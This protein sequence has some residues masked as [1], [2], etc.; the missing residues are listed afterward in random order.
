MLKN[1]TSSLLIAMLTSRQRRALQTQF[2]KS[3]NLPPWALEYEDGEELGSEF[4]EWA[5]KVKEE[6]YEEN[7]D[8]HI[9]VSSD[10]EGGDEEDNSHSGHT[11]TNPEDEGK[12]APKTGTFTNITVDVDDGHWSAGEAIDDD[13]EADSYDDEDEDDVFDELNG[14]NKAGP[15]G[16]ATSNAIVASGDPTDGESLCDASDKE[17]HRPDENTNSSAFN[18]DSDVGGYLS[19]AE[20]MQVSIPPPAC[21]TYIKPGNE[22]AYIDGIDY[23]ARQKQTTRSPLSMLV[24]QVNT[25]N[26][27]NA[28]EVVTS[29][30]AHIPTND[31]ET[32]NNAPVDAASDSGYSAGTDDVGNASDSASTD[33]EDRLA[34]IASSMHRS[35]QTRMKMLQLMSQH[36]LGRAGADQKR[37]RD[38][39]DEDEGFD[40]LP[41]GSRQRKI[42][43][44]ECGEES[45]E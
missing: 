11:S 16:P 33:T 1:L 8:G 3:G 44:R 2:N 17:N 28:E 30:E 35:F 42:T 14:D 13:D 6:T 25:P 36:C 24:G 29:E 5:K 23:Q 40:H 19:D 4:V 41:P 32:D 21:R 37:K 12:T 22:E 26:I 9:G 45:L 27:D 39:D 31:L 38:E 20:N 43:K 10:E 34:A 7:I 15:G 18:D